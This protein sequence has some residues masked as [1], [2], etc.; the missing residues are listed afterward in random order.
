MVGECSGIRH[1]YE[2]H[3]GQTPTGQQLISTGEPGVSPVFPLTSDGLE[4][5]VIGGGLY[6]KPIPWGYLYL[7]TRPAAGVR[8]TLAEGVIYMGT[9]GQARGVLV[10]GGGGTLRR[11]E[12]VDGQG[13][14]VVDTPF[15]TQ[16]ETAY[17]EAAGKVV[18]LYGSLPRKRVRITARLSGSVGESVLSALLDR[19]QIGTARGPD[20]TYVFESELGPGSYTATVVARDQ[21]GREASDRKQFTVS[22]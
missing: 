11:V 8:Q 16:L 4:G 17:V 19:T 9:D 14:S 2:C 6:D 5:V 10:F 21:L 13:F 3:V 15:Y 1:V 22:V 7:A 12:I 18:L 20:G